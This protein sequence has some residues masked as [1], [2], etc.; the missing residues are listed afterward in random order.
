MLDI[1]KSVNAS[2]EKLNVSGTP[3]ASIFWRLCFANDGTPPTRCLHYSHTTNA[4]KNRDYTR[5]LRK[6]R[7]ESGH[8]R[9]LAR[10]RNSDRASAS[11][12]HTSQA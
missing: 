10:R 9:H 2:H 7:L 3:Y 12:Y 4:S 1:A 5:D 11:P 8:V 6:E